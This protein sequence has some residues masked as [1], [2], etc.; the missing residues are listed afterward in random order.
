MN[1]CVEV[2]MKIL[3]QGAMENEFAYLLNFFQP[4]QH[5]N[6]AGYDFYITEYRGNSIIISRTGIGIINTSIATT[7]AI[8]RYA[9]D[10]I[11]NHG[12]A[13]GHVV[14]INVG[15][16]VIGEKAAYLND[17]Y[18]PLRA[19][20]EGSNSLE[21]L[22]NAKRSYVIDATAEFVELAKGIKMENKVLVGTLGSGDLY[23]REYD[24][25]VYLNQLFG[26]LCE[27]ME[28]VASF[29][30][31]ENFGVAHIAFRIISNNELLGTIGDMAI[32]NDLQ[33]FVI[34]FVDK[35]I[36]NLQLSKKSKK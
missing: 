16:I 2:F 4:T 28:T 24:R 8:N 23:S 25:I 10:L 11:I 15:D 30:V 32:L 6:I 14:D 31:C 19:K 33:Q 21:W 5:E 27:D 9:P 34:N 18:T 26:E 1:F 20:N 22:P 7:I 17:F 13:G 3:I 12:C 29:K 36:D 35:V